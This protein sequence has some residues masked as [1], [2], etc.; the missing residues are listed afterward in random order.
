[1]LFHHNVACLTEKQQIPMLVFGLARSALEPTVYHTQSD[2]STFMFVKTTDTNDHLNLASS[3]K[4]I[5]GMIVFLGLGLWC[6]TLLSTILQLYRGGQFYWW[7]KP[8][9]TTDLPQVTDILYHCCIE[10]T[11]P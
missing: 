7:K 10:H 1:M 8:E 6:L 3:F 9:N 11:S 2:L 5:A 4:S